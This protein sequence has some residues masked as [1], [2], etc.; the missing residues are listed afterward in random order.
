MSQFSFLSS[1]IENR[2]RDY[3][4]FN[5]REIEELTILFN[6]TEV[7]STLLGKTIEGR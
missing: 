2:K 6:S 5:D 7:L 3:K 4:A 1:Q